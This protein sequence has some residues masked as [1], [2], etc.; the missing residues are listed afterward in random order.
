MH[1]GCT[2]PYTF[3]CASPEIS[4]FCAMQCFTFL[5][6]TGAQNKW[7][8]SMLKQITAFNCVHECIIPY[9]YG[10]CAISFLFC[11]AT[12]L[13]A[14]TGI[15]HIFLFWQC[16]G[17]GGPNCGQEVVPF[18][19]GE[20][21][22]GWSGRFVPVVARTCPSCARETGPSWAGRSIPVVVERIVPVVSGRLVPVGVG[23]LAPVVRKGVGWSR[24]RSENWS[25][26]GLGGWSWFP[27]EAGTC[28]W[29][30]QSQLRPSHWPRLWLGQWSRLR[31]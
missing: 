17:Q 19:T 26:L 24:L 21:G 3:L 4:R 29:G 16:V 5:G 30:G 12:C 7:R 10:P 28:P 15:R 9:L 2:Q 22:S 14:S 1:G 13:P 27:W 8:K 11:L 20:T 18:W 25:R 23:T 31:R 6:D